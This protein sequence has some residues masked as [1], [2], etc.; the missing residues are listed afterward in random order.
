METIR[1]QKEVRA[2]I[3]HT[4]NYCGERIMPK[5]VYLKS[6]HKNDGGLYDWKAHKYCD[7]LVSTLKMDDDDGEGIT[8]D[9]FIESVSNAHFE[10][11]VAMFPKEEIKKYSDVIQQLRYVRFRDKLFYVIRYY[12]KLEK[13]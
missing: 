13:S 11:L 3:I 2:E 7:K 8:Q 1:Y 10:I 4:C 5:E 12:T 9:N 6:T